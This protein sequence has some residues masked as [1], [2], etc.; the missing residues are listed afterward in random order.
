MSSFEDKEK[1]AKG[2]NR[3][4]EILNQTTDSF[5]LSVI[6]ASNE[7]KKWTAVSRF[8]SGSG[9]WRLQNY[10]RGAL[11]VM[12]FFNDSQKEA[13]EANIKQA[14]TLSDLYDVQKESQK[15]MELIKKIKDE[16]IDSINEEVAANN[17]LAIAIQKQ[18]K[19]IKSTIDKAIED[20]KIQ[21]TEEEAHAEAIRRTATA[22]EYVESQ[23]K[24]NMTSR[25]KSFAKS[26]KNQMK[27]EEKAAK[28][29]DELDELVE[30]RE[31]AK[32][33]K[34][35]VK[36]RYVG[37]DLVGGRVG[38]F[39]TPEEDKKDRKELKELVK[40][41]RVQ[42]IKQSKVLGVLSLGL[43]RGTTKGL[44]EE[45][46]RRQKLMQLLK[47][48]PIGKGIINMREQIEKQGGVM[49]ILSKV[50][51]FAL[52]YSMYFL[53]FIMGAFV[54]FSFIREIFKNAEVMNTVMTAL[55]EIFG[56]V[57]LVLSGFFDIFQA[58]FG[59][60]TFGERL[61]MLVQGFGKIFGGLGGILMAVLKGILKLAVG[62]LVGIIATYWN[63]VAKV[64]H[65]LTNFDNYKKK[66]GEWWKGLDLWNRFTGWLG[67]LWERVTGFFGNL[68]D[69][70]FN[71]FANGG[72]VTGG[73]SIVGERGPELVNLPRGSR[74]HSNSASKNMLANRGNTTINVSVNG[75]MGASDSELRD[76]AKKIGRMVNTEINR[77]TS[78]STNVRY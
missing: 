69:N 74:V 32:A 68:F 26:I 1:Q 61:L 76:I 55:K 58:F 73:M 25:A 41:I 15:Q 23:I 5:A 63:M 65:V 24:K 71:P 60:G 35:A 33:A 29:K 48:S 30:L 4:L 6:N 46:T 52:T 43:T 59:S 14:Q 10:L 19:V 64:F 31:K 9:L 51:K 53:L 42:R 50:G 77:T 16:G 3:Q 57:F 11:Q 13:I 78:S 40:E 44:A 12:S 70:F 67:G 8:L 2:L 21:M 49:K 27:L 56:S 34:A 17:K 72:V 22:Y 38:R 36:E 75:R 54:V 7:S 20:K 37:Q 47:T 45:A 39:K 18:Y 62:L 66:L 28:R